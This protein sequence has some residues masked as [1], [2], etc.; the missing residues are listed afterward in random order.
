MPNERRSPRER[1]AVLLN[2]AAGGGRGAEKKAGLVKLLRSRGVPFDLFVT[3]SETHLRTL[4]R[5]KC[6]D[7][8]VLAG[9]GGDSTF[10][11]MAEEIAQAGEPVRL[12][13]IGLGSSNDIP[14]EFG[15]ETPEKFVAALREGKERR[16]DLGCVEHE[17]QR[18]K[19]FIGQASIGLGAFVNEFAARVGRL[20]PR[21]ARRQTA[22]GVWGVA[23]AYRGRLIPVPLAVESEGGRTEG[24][25]HVATFAN[26]RFWATGR[27]LVPQAR[28]DDGR[29]DACL[30]R[31]CSFLRFARLAASVR[32]G[33]HLRAPEV[34]WSQSS[35]FTVSSER[36]FAVQVDGELVGEAGSPSLFEN[37]RLRVMPAA[38]TII[39]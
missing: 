34:E 27:L 31:Q 9:A 6:H 32:S 38:I 33:R 21:L 19:I 15:V 28:P 37:I 14:L 36:P 13:M 1:L 4:T 5:E 35:V 22:I 18:L 25:F 30:I 24:L 7:Y 11:I 39:A 2:P 20:R 8:D 12:G 17:G 29:L 16:I 23:R 3:E 10:Q 26:I